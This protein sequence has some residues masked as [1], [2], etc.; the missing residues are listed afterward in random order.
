MG[1]L[2]RASTTWGQPTGGEDRAEDWADL[3]KAG[4]GGGEGPG[5]CEELQGRG[6]AKEKGGPTEAGRGRTRHGRSQYREGRAG[7]RASAGVVGNTGAGPVRRT[8][9]GAGSI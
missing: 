5:L 1:I 4:V 2:D 3:G 9:K 7:G 6:G 8:S